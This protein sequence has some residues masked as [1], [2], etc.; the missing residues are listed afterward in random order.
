MALRPCKECK[1]EV[2]TSATN[3]P[4]CGAPVKTKVGCGTVIAGSALFLIFMVVLGSI[5]GP[6]SQVE[7]PA[8]STLASAPTTLD[9]PAAP[10]TPSEPSSPWAYSNLADAMHEQKTKTGCTTSTNKVDLDWPYSDVTA[11]LC[12]RKG[13]R[14]GLDAYVQLNGDGQIL[15][16]IWTCTVRI[17]FDKGAAR[18]FTAVGAADHSSNIIFIK[19]VPKLVQALKKSEKTVI[20]IELYQAGVQALEFPTRQFEWP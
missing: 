15:C 10:E 14:F 17:R 18:A 19:G 5:V 1:T 13:P 9:A 4:K 12:I 8:A 6:R 3:C 20:E 2:S 7:P 16:K 11:D